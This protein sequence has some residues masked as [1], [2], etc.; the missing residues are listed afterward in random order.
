MMK[1]LYFDMDGV[2]VD[3]DS[4]LAKQPKEVLDKYKEHPDN[5]PGLFAEMDPIP[6]GLEAAHKL[7]NKYDCYI[8]STAP[9]HNPSA[10][11]DKVAWITERAEDIFRKK[12]ILTHHKGFLNDGISFLIDDRDKHG[13]DEFG[14]RHIQLWSDKFPDWDSV[15]DYLLSLN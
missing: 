2:L 1:K 14:E 5:I 9:W 3:F 13:A 8:L 15:V 12:V 10:W 7:A 11:G 4:A 6:G